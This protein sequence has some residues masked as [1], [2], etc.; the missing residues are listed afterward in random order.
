MVVVAVVAVTPAERVVVVPAV[1][2]VVPGVVVVVEGLVSH[3]IDKVSLATFWF[4]AASVNLFAATE[5]SAVPDPDVGGAHVA[6]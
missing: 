3:T 2:V 4:P 5:I 6:V 1:V